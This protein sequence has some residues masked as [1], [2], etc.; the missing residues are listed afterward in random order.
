MLSSSIAERLR[1]LGRAGNEL[2]AALET[3]GDRL[4]DLTGAEILLAVNRAAKKLRQLV[5]EVE[6]GGGDGQGRGGR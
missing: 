3:A 1:D 5:E 4:P 6:A 2:K